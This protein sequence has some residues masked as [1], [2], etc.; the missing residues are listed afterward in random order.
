MEENNNQNKITRNVI[1]FNKME[2][3]IDTMTKDPY[4]LKKGYN[5]FLEIE[6]H[7]NF[8]VNLL[9]IIFSGKHT[10]QHVKLSCS[11]LKNFLIKNWSDDSC[12]TNEERLV[13]FLVKSANSKLLA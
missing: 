5:I 11:V 3:M 2:E 1:E 10:E 7:R 6:K 8:Y 4:S 13:C 12:I 9:Q